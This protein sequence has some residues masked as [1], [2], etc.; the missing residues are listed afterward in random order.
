MTKLCVCGHPMYKHRFKK[1]YGTKIF[2]SCKIS[3]CNCVEFEQDYTYTSK[4]KKPPVKAKRY[5][6]KDCNKQ[7]TSMG[8]AL[9]HS[10]KKGHYKFRDISTDELKML[11]E[12]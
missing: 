1:V 12:K 9:R 11:E 5:A 2:S 4:I 8:W 7:Y 3:G 6:C 10:N